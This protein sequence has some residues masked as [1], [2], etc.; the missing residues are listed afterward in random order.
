[1][2]DA[3][4]DYVD[5]IAPEH[6]PLFDRGGGTSRRAGQDEDGATGTA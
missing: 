6:R 3:V 2:D 4:R 1:M 5:A